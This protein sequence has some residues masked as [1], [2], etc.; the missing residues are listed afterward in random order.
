MSRTT[1]LI[2]NTIYGVAGKV[3]TLLLSFASR[4]AVIYLLGD[5]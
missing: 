5:T 4:T 2:R 3:L 1:N